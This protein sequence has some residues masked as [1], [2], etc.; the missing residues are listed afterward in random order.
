LFGR[1]AAAGDRSSPAARSA[2]ARRAENFAV[3]A[4]RGWLAEAPADFRDR[5]L[6]QCLVK[7]VARDAVIY[8][9]GDP[10]DGLFGVV[11]G[12]VGVEFASDH[13]ERYVS[14]YAGGGFWF[15]DYGFLT[16][17]P[18]LWGMRAARDTE[19]VFLPSRRWRALVQAEP[20]AWRWFAHH[21]LQNQLVITR[22]A[23][24]LLVRESRARIGAIL[25]IL[26][27]LAHPDDSDGEP[28]VDI[29]QEDMARICNLS[30]GTMQRFLDGMEKD[31]LIARGYRRIVLRD[32]DGLRAAASA[33]TA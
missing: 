2:A 6:G 3:F 28:S 8:R 30:R 26:G 19:L 21:V 23:D 32:R 22:M 27:D 31:G 14:L 5:V 12:A 20:E 33:V 9:P 24:A 7:R 13:R 4:R 25:L 10:G 1:S 16:G 18:R 17:G 15:G 29:T 11:S